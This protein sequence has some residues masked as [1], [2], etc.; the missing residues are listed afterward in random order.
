MELSGQSLCFLVTEHPGW[1]CVCNTTIDLCLL[2]RRS[3]QIFI[4]GRGTLLRSTD[5][6]GRFH[7]L[8]LGLY[9]VGTLYLLAYVLPR[10][11]RAIPGDKVANEDGW[12][13]TWNL[14]WTRYALAHGQNPYTTEM[15]FY[16]TGARLYLHTLTLTNGV[17][18][19]PVQLL[20]GPV[21]A[22]NAALVLGFVL[23]GYASFLLAEHVIGQRGIA[24]AVGAIVTFSPFHV[25]KMWDGH[26]SWVTMQ[27]VPLYVY[28]LLVALQS[29]RWRMRV[30]AGVF[31][32]VA[33]L[34]SWYYALFS[35]IFTGLLFVVRG[36]ALLRGGRWRSEV[37]TY[38]VMGGVALVLLAPVLIPTLGEYARGQYPGGHG[39]KRD[40]Y[41]GIANY[42]ADVF[43]MIFPSHLHPVWGDL[44]ARLHFVLRPRIWFWVISPGY[45]VLLLAMLGIWRRWGQTRPWALLCGG[46][47]ILMLGP[48]LYVA[49][50]DTG[51]TMPYELLRVIPGMALGHRPNHLAVF[52]LPWLGVLA[53]YGI[54]TLL[55]GGRTGKMLLGVLGGVIVCEY[56]VLP[57]PV[58]PYELHPVFAEIRHRP[59]AVVE[60]P[61]DE[62]TAFAMKHQMFHERPIV[63]GYLA[64]Q[65][66]RPPFVV[67]LPW[68]RELW[69]MYPTAEADII[70]ARPD[71]GWQAFSY[72]NIRTLVVRRDGLL[73]VQERDIPR[74]IEHVL[75]GIAPV[76]TDADITLY[77]IEPAGMPRPFVYLGPEWLKYEQEGKRGWRWMGDAATVQ[78]VNPA[79]AARQVTLA[80]SAEAYGET[81]PLMV[82]LD[83]FALGVFDI[84][85]VAQR[86]L[87][88]SVVL[89]PGEHRLH[90][91]STAGR[92][93][94]APHRALSLSFTR[95]ELLDE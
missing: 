77:E 64:R 16:P 63:G 95:I 69:Q 55:Q 49:G 68:L 17:L 71:D 30:L 32:A 28:C 50:V 13:N 38:L 84:P 29:G 86:L 3:G 44:S 47:F 36:P 92:E 53:G 27:W 12:Q 59:G 25:S 7:L 72:F 62:R 39:I 48:S 26:L 66:G 24:C 23:T 91:R 18:T 45:G 54:L 93:Q 35:L 15:L 33:T 79:R 87:R 4:E 78:V 65:P 88:L 89:P 40:W 8:V 14:W 43:D 70:P 61:P 60:L 2:C 46:L 80:L 90:F 56:A 34:T 22:Y 52:L 11:D 9:L 37:V 58:L 74:V 94:D 42:S 10:F 82:S 57:M 41:E 1:Y 19:L 6:R 20:A 81:R 5:W 75:P 76:Y 51:L 21:A 85:S 31:L 67:A 83:G 73:S